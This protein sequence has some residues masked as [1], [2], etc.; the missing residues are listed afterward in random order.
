[1]VEVWRSWYERVCDKKS[2]LVKNLNTQCLLSAS[3]QSCSI[4]SLI[5]LVLTVLM[6]PASQSCLQRGC[7]CLS[8]VYPSDSYHI[9]C[10]HVTLST[11]EVTHSCQDG[12]SG[13]ILGVKISA[14]IA[15]MSLKQK[16]QIALHKSLSLCSEP[17]KAQLDC[18]MTCL[19]SNYHAQ[20]IFHKIRPSP[21]VYGLITHL[22]WFK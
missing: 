10:S 20:S 15:L 5:R 11:P 1:M 12:E 22:K 9:G 21:Y 17:V 14:S 18:F 4:P 2:W 16:G 6:C 3:W 19:D 13:P 7:N 8:C